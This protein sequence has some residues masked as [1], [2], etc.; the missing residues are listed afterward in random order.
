MNKLISIIVPVKNGEKYLKEAIE[1]IQKQGMNLEIIVVNDASTDQTAQIA[2]ELGC[3][4]VNHKKSRGQV[5]A[6]NTGLQNARG[7]Y[8]IFHDGDDVMNEHALQ[9][10]Y[11][12]LEAD[13]SVSAVMGKVKDFISP[14]CENPSEQAKIIKPEAYYGLFTG[15]VLMQRKIFDQIGLFDENIHTGEIIEWKNKMQTHHLAIKTIDVVTTNRRVHDHNFG[16]THRLTEF[17][18]YARVLRQKLRKHT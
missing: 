14:D 3:I 1:G 8:V 12:T 16:K 17:Q 9:I 13:P 18:D 7:T 10:L 4:V 15:A 5:V 11:D 2:S 6:K